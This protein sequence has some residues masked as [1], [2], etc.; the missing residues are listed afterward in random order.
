MTLVATVLCNFSEGEDPGV[1]M[2]R[3]WSIAAS[4][5]LLESFC[6]SIDAKSDKITVKISSGFFPN[7]VEILKGVL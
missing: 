1:K 7:F 3:I 5:V 2:R 4:C 6:Q